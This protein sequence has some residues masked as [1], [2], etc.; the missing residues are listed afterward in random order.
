M[1][2]FGS[3]KNKD[4]PV[5]RESKKLV[6]TASAEVKRP[7]KSSGKKLF[8]VIKN[9]RITEKATF[10]SEKN[11][12]TFDVALNSNEQMVKQAVKETYG[13]TPLKVNMLNIRG[14]KVYSRG[15]EGTTAKSKK[16]YVYLKAGDK[17]EFA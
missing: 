13:V 15:K 14:K 2:I 11:I 1:A 10:V 4:A 8:G 5:K 16:A 12:Y 17:I 9:P 6:E 3:K 7:V